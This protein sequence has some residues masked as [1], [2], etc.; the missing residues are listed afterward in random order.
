VVAGPGE[1]K[2]RVYQLPP[3]RERVKNLTAQA[4]LDLLRRMALK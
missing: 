1:T 2:H 4:A 3:P